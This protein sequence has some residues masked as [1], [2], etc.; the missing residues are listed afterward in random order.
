VKALAL[1]ITLGWAL[2][3]TDLWS[4]MSFVFGALVLLLLLWEQLK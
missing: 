2:G 1:L 4:A 3:T